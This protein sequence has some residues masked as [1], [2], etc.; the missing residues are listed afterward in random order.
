MANIRELLNKKPWIGWCVAGAA[1]CVAS[2]FGWKANKVEGEYTADRMTQVLT[3]RFTDTGDT[4]EIPRGRLM[5]DLMLAGGKLDPSKGI[6]NPKTG[7]ATGFPFS[8]DDWESMVAQINRD[9]AP[10][11]GQQA[12]AAGPAPVP[13]AAPKAK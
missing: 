2:Y 5:R 4:M 13:P 9:M 1:V 6:V 8:K 10:P 11:G 12:P 3:I 7:Q